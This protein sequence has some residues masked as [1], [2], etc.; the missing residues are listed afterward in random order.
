LVCLGAYCNL[1]YIFGSMYCINIIMF[2]SF[3]KGR[4]LWLIVWKIEKYIYFLIFLFSMK[5][6]NWLLLFEVLKIQGIFWL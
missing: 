2:F 6:A 5:V 3:D 4:V 1:S